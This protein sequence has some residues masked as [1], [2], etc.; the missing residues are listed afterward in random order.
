M[1][2]ARDDRRRCHSIFKFAT[3]IEMPKGPLL[4][5]FGLTEKTPERA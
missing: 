1:M 4:R 5:L 3:E 2:E